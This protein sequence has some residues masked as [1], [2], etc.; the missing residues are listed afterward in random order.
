MQIRTIFVP[1]FGAYCI[2]PRE[3]TIF[4][5][6]RWPDDPRYEYPQFSKDDVVGFKV[7]RAR[8]VFALPTLGYSERVPFVETGVTGVYT[9]NSSQIVNGTLNVNETVKLGNEFVRVYGV[10]KTS[11]PIQDSRRS[12]PADPVLV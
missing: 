4:M 8:H 3:C 12:S 7:S 11:Q 9:V 5:P 6:F 10:E 2:E 1:L